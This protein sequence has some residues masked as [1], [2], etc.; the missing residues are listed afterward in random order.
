MRTWR[1]DLALNYPGAPPRALVHG[2]FFTSYNSSGACVCL[3][4][5]GWGAAGETALRAKLETV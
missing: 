3:V 1:T 2:G 4:G 5:E